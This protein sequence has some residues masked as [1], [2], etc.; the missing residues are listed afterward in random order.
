MGCG[1]GCSALFSA[2][3]DARAYGV[4]LGL[5][6]V[7]RWSFPKPSQA[8]RTETYCWPGSAISRSTGHHRGCGVTFPNRIRLTYAADSPVA[9]ASSPSGRRRSAASRSGVS[10]SRTSPSHSRIARWCSLFR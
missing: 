10:R 4:L 1:W 5:R 7:A 2:S 3:L 9:A 8:D 6:S